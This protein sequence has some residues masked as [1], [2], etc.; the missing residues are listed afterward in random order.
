MKSFVCEKMGRV[1]VLHLGKGELLLES[2]E[3]E[4]QRLNVRNAVLLSCIGSL[5]KCVFHYITSTSDLATDSFASI[6]KPLELSAMQ[7]IVLNGKAHF[8]LVISDEDRV[9]SG[10]LEGGCEVQY[11][12]EISLLELLDTSLERRTDEYGILYIDEIK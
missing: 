1:I 12:M 9:Y 2:I 3:Q 4:L 11:L 5:R 10:H 8:H 7:G 6:E